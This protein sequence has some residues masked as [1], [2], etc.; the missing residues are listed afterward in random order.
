MA[1]SS[2]QHK[3]CRMG[4]PGAGRSAAA[5]FPE[6]ASAKPVTTSVNPERPPP[7]LASKGC[8]AFTGIRPRRDEVS[9]AQKN[10]VAAVK[11]F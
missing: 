11:P 9:E 8:E 5:Q 10:R 1:N 7:A 3:R 4:D 2:T 6:S